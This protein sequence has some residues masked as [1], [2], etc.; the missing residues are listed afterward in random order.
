LQH[1]EFSD[2]TGL[3]EY[4]YGAR[5]QDPQLGV[6]HS[7]DPLAE[8]SRRWSPY[9]YGLDNP[10]RFIDPDG[11][12][13]QDA[14]LGQSST[15]QAL[16]DYA[17]QTGLSFGDVMAAY[18]SGGL[19]TTSGGGGGDDKTKQKPASKKSAPPTPPSA[20]A[21][22]VKVDKTG[23][24]PN[25]SA[26]RSKILQKQGCWVCLPQTFSYGGGKPGEGVGDKYDPNKPF[27]FIGDDAMETLN[28][29]MGGAPEQPEMPDPE[30]AADVANHALEQSGHASQG[31]ASHNDPNHVCVNC[32]IDI[33]D[34]DPTAY[35]RTGPNG[36]VI[37]TIRHVGRDTS[38][39]V[40][41]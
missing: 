12:D 32:E 8:A 9:N 36:H 22:A 41:N 37:D 20:S 34:P 11:M 30:L 29:I 17:N 3:E 2:G 1:Q 18:I 40:P 7:I 31:S 35:I 26:T 19:N 4:D 6:W 28:T 39:Y 15:T 14:N 13:G 5:F 24:A 16:Q 25:P 38:K 33:Y 10:I 23:V 21:T 27:Q